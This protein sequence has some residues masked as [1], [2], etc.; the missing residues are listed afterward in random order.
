MERL[1]KK[2]KKEEEEKKKEEKKEKEEEEERKEKNKNGCWS[3]E[4]VWE[5]WDWFI[6]A[7]PTTLGQ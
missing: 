2:R 7:T 3:L 1:Q 5:L 6:T 4:L